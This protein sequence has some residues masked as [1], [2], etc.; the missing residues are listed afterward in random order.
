MGGSKHH[1]EENLI[2]PWFHHLATHLPFSNW[3]NPVATLRTPDLC[4][5]I[6]AIESP[7]PV[8]IAY[9]VQIGGI[10]AHRIRTE[11][12]YYYEVVWY[13]VGDNGSQ[14]W[15]EWQSHSETEGWWPIPFPALSCGLQNVLDGLMLPV[16][17]LDLIFVLRP[18]FWLL[19]MRAPQM[20]SILLVLHLKS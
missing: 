4:C 14:V 12:C 11:P 17:G 3:E 2:H 16:S 13:F 19:T 6:Y 10:I 9:S 1:G 7:F 15:P 5:F 18:Q 20:A 8:S